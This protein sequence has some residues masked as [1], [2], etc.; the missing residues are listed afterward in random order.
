MSLHRHPRLDIL[1]RNGLP[2]HLLQK[3]CQSQLYRCLDIS[4][5]PPFRRL[6]KEI[7]RGKFE[8]TAFWMQGMHGVGEVIY[9]RPEKNWFGSWMLFSR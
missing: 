6:Y 1:V 4:P 5:E 9:G 3:D 8:G 2:S 7:R